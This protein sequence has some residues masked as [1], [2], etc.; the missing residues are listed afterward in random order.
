MVEKIGVITDRRVMFSM[1]SQLNLE[2]KRSEECLGLD[3]L[4]ETLL[5]KKAT[6]LIDILQFPFQRIQE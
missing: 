3:H 6:L 5:G 1:I 4:V 2:R